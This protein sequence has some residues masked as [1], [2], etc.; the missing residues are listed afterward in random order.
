MFNIKIN[1]EIIESLLFFWQASNDR[2]KIKEA[3][4]VNLA[5]YE[6]MKPLYSDDFSKDSVRKV[7]SAISNRELLSIATKTERKFW[8]NNMWMMEDLEYTEM[9]IKPIKLLNLD[10]F[11]KEI[12]SSKS[13]TEDVEILFIPGMYESHI[14]EDNKLYINFF[15]VKP[16][17][18]DDSIVTIDDVDFNEFIKTKILSIIE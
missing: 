12:N 3:Y 10:E 13:L 6:G 4:M 18:M 1:Q 15:Y 7:L 14:I 9:M 2:E 5:D 8:N 16:D 11:A 17:L